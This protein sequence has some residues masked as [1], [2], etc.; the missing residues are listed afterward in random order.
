MI[1]NITQLV[2]YEATLRLEYFDCPIAF[3]SEGS[4]VARK[5]KNNLLNPPRP[6]LME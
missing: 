5:T 3:V 1:F 2:F 6:F 4:R